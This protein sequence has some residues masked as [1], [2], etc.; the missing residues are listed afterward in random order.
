M[1]DRTAEE[2]RQAVV[3]AALF[4]YQ[5]Q[6]FID[7]HVPA[8]PETFQGDVM[9]HLPAGVEPELNAERRRWEYWRAVCSP[10]WTDPQIDQYQYKHWCGAFTLFCLKQAGLAQ[11][12][13]WRDGI[14]Y[15]EPNR[16][17]KVK[18]PQPGDVAYFAKNS[19]YAIVENVRT[20][21]SG[22]VVFDSIDGN[23]GKTL[24]TPSIKRYSSRAVENVAAFY[25]IESLL[26]EP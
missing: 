16:F 26:G 17:D 11:S 1:S 24:A 12:I 13:F 3:F 20:L 19:H 23:Q 15:V 22:A 8:H 7:H 4:E 14:G 6:R 25:S 21:P 2:K 10:S 5:A 18:I 9:G